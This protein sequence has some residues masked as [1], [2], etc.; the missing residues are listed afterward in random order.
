[1]DQ[2][3][4]NLLEA[5][6]ERIE[7]T[8]KR[9]MRRPTQKQARAMQLMVGNGGNAS[10]AMRG[11][12]YSPAMVHNPHKFLGSK[13]V[14]E[15]IKQ[16]DFDGIINNIESIAK[17]PSDKRAAIGAA[18]LT[19]RVGDVYPAEKRKLMSLFDNLDD[20]EED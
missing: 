6:E 18:H 2:N 12:G 19:F 4:N 1:M 14:Q 7:Q 8:P 3:E 17:D 15:R 20:L 5:T 13:A 11:A 9:V 16:I 10:A